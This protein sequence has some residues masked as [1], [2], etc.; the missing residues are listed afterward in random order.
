MAEGNDRQEQRSKVLDKSSHSGYV[1]PHSKNGLPSTEK[2][3]FVLLGYIHIH[4]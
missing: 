1:F 2:A 3:T 4:T